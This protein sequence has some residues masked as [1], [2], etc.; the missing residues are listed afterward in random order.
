VVNEGEPVFERT[1]PIDVRPGAAVNNIH[2]A[3]QQ[4]IK[5]ALLSTST[6]STSS[7]VASSLRFGQLGNEASLIG[8]KP[9]QDV[10][11][12]GRADLVCAFSLQAAQFNAASSTATVRGSLVD[13]SLIAGT[14]PVPILGAEAGPGPSDEDQSQ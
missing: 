2:L 6:F 7:V 9:P 14:D 13:G 3:G 12:D 8:C 5:V 11:G 4:R 10:N 1:I